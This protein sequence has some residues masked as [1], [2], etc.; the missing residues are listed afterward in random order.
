[1]WKNGRLGENCTAPPKWSANAKSGPGFRCTQPGL[2]G[3]SQ[4][5]GDLLAVVVELLEP[6]RVTQ[7]AARQHVADQLRAA[8]DL[9]VAFF[10]RQLEVED[11]ARARAVRNPC[12]D[13]LGDAR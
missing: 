13:K 11:G 6:Q 1:M 5:P 3:A 7:A 9:G 8:L 10:H 2:L 4:V 12:G